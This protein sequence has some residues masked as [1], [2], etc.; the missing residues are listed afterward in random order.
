MRAHKGKMHARRMKHTCAQLCLMCAHVCT[1]L[2]KNIFES[3]SL[4]N[5][6]NLNSRESLIFNYEDISKI[7]YFAFIS[8]YNV[9]PKPSKMDS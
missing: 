2:N 1:D 3:P 9:P 5:E 6:L 4:S 8:S 7:M